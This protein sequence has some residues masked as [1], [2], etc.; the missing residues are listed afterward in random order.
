MTPP[1]DDSSSTTR[2]P[3]PRR[4]RPCSRRWR[5]TAAAATRSSGGWRS[6][7]AWRCWP[8]WPSSP[9]RR[10]R[11]RWPAFTARGH[12]ASSR[13]TYWDPTGRPVR[14]PGLHLRHAAVVVHRPA[15]RRAGQPRHRPVHHR[16]GAPAAAQAGHLRD[17]P[18]G[19]GAVGRLRP[20]GRARAA[21]RTSSPSTSRSPTPPT[22]SRCS[23]RSS[24]GTAS[25]KQLHDRR[26]HPR[27]HDHAD[28]HL[29]QPGGHRHRARA[30]SARRPTA[31][32]PP[33]G[34]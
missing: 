20:V 23:A 1:S 28:R 4:L 15:L 3:G 30:R 24:A 6:S 21:P 32:A 9:G 7:P 29:A 18:A 19:R 14:G 27:H 25:G 10:P 16:G 13:P 26:A 17:R 8:S 31:W 5:A 33:A 34:R 12:L 22:A 11:R 2:P